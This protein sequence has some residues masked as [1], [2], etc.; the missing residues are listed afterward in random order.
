LRLLRRGERTL[1]D[2]ALERRPHQFHIMPIGAVQRQP[3]RYPMPLRQ[4]TALDAT[5]GAL[6][7]IGA[8]FF[9]RLAGLCSA[10]HP[11]SARPSRSPGVRQTGR[12]RL[13]RGAAR[14]PPPPTAETGREPS[15]WHRTRSDLRPPTGS[16]GAA[17]RKSHRRSAG[18]APGD[19][20]R[21][22]DGRSRGAVAGA[23]GRSTA[24]RKCE[25][26]WWCGYS[27]F[28]PVFVLSLSWSVVCSWKLV[29]QLFG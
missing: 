3:Q 15:I 12:L 4:Q 19:V 6:G 11:G 5:F 10:R 28:S 8:R 1:H 20:L 16:R 18:R 17:Q 7:G 26:P 2:Q 25:N 14:R 21:Q 22:S 27:G 29:Y 24:H 13:A 9:F 23:P